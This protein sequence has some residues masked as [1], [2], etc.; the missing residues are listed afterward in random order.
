MT[1]ITLKIAGMHCASCK[2]LIEDVASGLPG[3]NACS[4]DLESGA[5]ALEVD[6]RLFRPEAFAAEVAALGNYAVETI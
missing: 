3:V 4:V 2:A 6:E 1:T 5:A